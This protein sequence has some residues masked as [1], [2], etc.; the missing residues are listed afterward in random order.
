M[1]QLLCINV[2]T[3]V[4]TITIL[5]I[6]LCIVPLQSTEQ[7]KKLKVYPTQVDDEGK[8]YAKFYTAA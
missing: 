7:P 6:T 8:I 1:L 2:T 5:P 4:T 3:D